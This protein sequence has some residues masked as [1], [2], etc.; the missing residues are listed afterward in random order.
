MSTTTPA[1]VR[2]GQ[3]A[4]DDQADQAD[5]A[6]Q[7]NQQLPSS[8]PLDRSDPRVPAVTRQGTVILLNGTSSS[9]KSSIAA[10]LLEILDDTW[11]H[12]PVDAVHAMRS[13]R[14]ISDEDL[15]AELV[16]TSMG[17]HRAVAGMAAAGNN[18]VVDHVLSFAWRLSDCLDL[19]DPERVVFVGVR[20]PLEETVAREAARGD[21][22]VGQAASQFDQVHAHGDY[23]LEVDTSVMSPRQCAERV[24][25]HL[26]HRASPT[27]FS[28]LRSGRTV[29]T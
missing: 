17:F 4:Y 14:E 12:L 3:A 15:P 13:Q 26:S 24:R 18:V 28:R 25:E 8:N 5:Q 11:F 16:R 27:A 21:R 9:G 10:E 23:D 29:R 1:A 2:P 20:C 7:V 22:P 19:L 6:D